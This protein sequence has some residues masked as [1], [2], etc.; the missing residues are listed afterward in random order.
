MTANFQFESLVRQYSAELY[1]FAFWL[2]KNPS[3]A[4]D[5]V[6]EAFLRAWKSMGELREADSAKAW[7]MTIVRREYLRTLERKRLDTVDIDEVI[8]REE[9]SVHDDQGDS[10]QVRQAMLKLESKYR[11][12]LVLQVLGGLS[13]QE[14]ASQ[15][16]ISEAAVMT[17]L[18]RARQKLK[19][20]LSPAQSVAAEAV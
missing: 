15:L 9:P 10:D 16:Q 17:Q 19:D 14:I 20:I 12:P 11:V 2:S 6:Q 3:L 1:R 13:C 8:G 5:V 18:F 7:L 4:Q